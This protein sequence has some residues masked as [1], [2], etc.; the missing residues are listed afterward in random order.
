M[1]ETRVNRMICFSLKELLGYTK[2]IRY[3]E[4]PG[5]NIVLIL[6]IYGFGYSDNDDNTVIQQCISVFIR[7]KFNIT[8]TT[9]IAKAILSMDYDDAFVAY[10]NNVEI[11]RSG[12]SGLKTV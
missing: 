3:K 5:T 6:R 11:T 2:V 10:M 9:V 4:R 7:H 8:D 12:I 1:P